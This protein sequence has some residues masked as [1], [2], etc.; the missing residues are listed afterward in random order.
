LISVAKVTLGSFY[1][2]LYAGQ[3]LPRYVV[4]LQCQVGTLKIFR[5]VKLP[6]Q[7][8]VLCFTVGTIIKQDIAPNDE[9]RM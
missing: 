8:L 3:Q 4:D 2:E 1:V 9:S 5:F 7:S 6:D